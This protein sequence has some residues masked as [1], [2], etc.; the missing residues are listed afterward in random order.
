MLAA[1]YSK[2]IVEQQAAG[3]SYRLLY[4]DGEFIDAV[5]K[6]P[7]CIVGDG[8]HTLAQLIRN[9]NLRRLRGVAP[10]AMQ[11]LVVDVELK[12]C[13]AGQGL[14]M[15]SVVAANKRVVVKAVVNEN[16]AAENSSVRDRVHPDTIRRGAEIARLLRIRLA[17]HDVITPDISR[18]LAETGGV[19]NEVNTTPGL[20]HHY[21]IDFP[22]RAF[23]VMERL[24][25]VLLGE[26][27][28]PQ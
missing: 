13:L 14:A 9:E 16:T 19:F 28:W 21:L 3:P 20:Q 5:E 15:S 24:L 25:E 4:I 27:E 1:T 23:P 26:R 7:P 11:P 10:L 18:P 12:R 2:T 22:D 8:R 6:R 17:G